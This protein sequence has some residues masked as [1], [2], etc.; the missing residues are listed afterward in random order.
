MQPRRDITASERGEHPRGGAGGGGGVGGGGG[1][2]EG[3]SGGSR[4]A[5]SRRS[6]RRREMSD[7]KR[8]ASRRSCAGE[9]NVQL[10]EIGSDRL[11]AFKAWRQA[12]LTAQLFTVEKPEQRQHAVAIE[13][14]R[15]ADASITRMRHRGRGKVDDE[16]VSKRHGAFPPVSSNR[17]CDENERD[18]LLAVRAGSTHAHGPTTACGRT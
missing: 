6:P 16:P 12:F 14:V 9:E 10:V 4:V 5:E 7:A 8:S 13:L 2:V 3:G 15:P 11:A 1:G 18:A 17:A